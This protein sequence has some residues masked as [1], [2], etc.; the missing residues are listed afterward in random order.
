MRKFVLTVLLLLLLYPESYSNAES[1]QFPLNQRIKI[2]FG[3]EKVYRDSL[4]NTNNIFFKSAT[5]TILEAKTYS[6]YLSLANRFILWRPTDTDDPD[7]YGSGIAVL[8]FDTPEGHFKIHYT[9][10]ETNGDAVD[11]SDGDP[12]IIPQFIIDAGVAFENSYSHVLSLGYP[13][14]PNDEGKGGDDRLDVYILNIPGSFGYTS[15]DNNPED[16]YI[17]MDN[18]FATVPN[19]LDPDGKQKG[20]IKVTAAHE[21]FHAFHFQYST[22]IT[23]NGWWMEATS[24]WMEDEVYPE[25]KDYLN[26]IGLRYDDAN[27]NGKWDIGETYYNID[28]SIAGAIGR[29]KKWFDKPEIPLDTYN[30]SYEYGSV[31]WAKYLSETHGKVI[32][33]AIWSKIGDGATALEA[34]SD[35]LESLGITLDSTYNS[36][37]LANYKR[38]Y[39]DGSYYPIIK[40]EDSFTF[41]PQST[42][43]LIKH[44]SSNYYAFKADSTTSNF[45]LT[46]NE[47]DSGNLA[48]KLVLIKVGGGYDEQDVI[49]DS[50][51]VT[52]QIT[53]FGTSATYSKVVVIIMNTSSSQNGEIFSIDTSKEVLSS[54][55]NGGGDGCFIAT[56]AYGSP[57]EPHVKV[58]RDFRDRFLLTNSVGKAL[59]GLYHTYSPSVADFIARHDTVCLLVRW[60]FLPLVGMSWMALHL[61]PWFTLALMGLLICLMG[62]AAVFTIRRIMLRH[63]A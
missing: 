14:L 9:E 48:I 58:L 18:D 15:Y 2:I 63:H 56:A 13:T 42:S 5:L 6:E 57:M 34:I 11:G 25:V 30:G 32:I 41:Y 29:S 40:H 52:S 54:P 46:F 26:Y 43:G 36:F 44:L 61:G 1:Y 7:Y 50:P 37:Q 49:L 27:D 17:V 33:K 59:V 60:S 38:D 22:D 39:P 28:G 45:A 4:V 62:T 8:T 31:I 51:S 12:S 10:D 16:V 21:L 19:N 47:M 35:E 55:S 53:N 3:K 24:V 20:A 23:N